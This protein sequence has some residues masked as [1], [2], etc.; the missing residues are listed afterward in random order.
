MDLYKGRALWPGFR[1]AFFLKKFNYP[2][3][4]LE[5]SFYWRIQRD[6]SQNYN[7][8]NNN[9]NNNNYNNPKPRIL[10]ISNKTKIIEIE[11]Y[12]LSSDIQSKANFDG[13]GSRFRYDSYAIET[14]HYFEIPVLK[15]SMKN[16]ELA[17]N[18][19]QNVRLCK[20][21]FK[22]KMGNGSCFDKCD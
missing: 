19:I 20:D 3:D 10:S 4:I 15:K 12:L 14:D 2:I 6:Y 17:C 1:V 16:K 21:I 7:N 8:N 5:P 22:P 18:I 9:N 13:L 11:K